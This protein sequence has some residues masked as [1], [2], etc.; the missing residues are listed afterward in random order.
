MPRPALPAL[1][2]N[3]LGVDGDRSL[4]EDVDVDGFLIFFV[5]CLSIALWT[6]RLSKMGREVSIE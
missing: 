2:V 6:T 1:G 4:D 3:G 5:N